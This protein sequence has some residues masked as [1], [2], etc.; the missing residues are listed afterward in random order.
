M[1]DNNVPLY[2]SEGE[3]R[4]LATM[5]IAAR[6][7][8]MIAGEILTPE[9][10]KSLTLGDRRTVVFEGAKANIDRAKIQDIT[11]KANPPSDWGDATGD[12]P[13]DEPPASLREKLGA[14]RTLEAE[15]W[16]ALR[17]LDRF[18]FELVA[19]EGPPERLVK[20]YEGLF[21]REEAPRPSPAA[22]GHFRMV[23]THRATASARV[24]M[25]VETLALFLGGDTPPEQM[26]AM[27]RV[28]G[29]QAGKH[30]SS[31]LP[32]C[33][34]SPI[35]RVEV[36][37][38]ADYSLGCVNIKATVEAVEKSGVDT[39]A[40]VAASVAALTIGDFAKHVDRAV[41]IT[42]VQLV[43]DYDLET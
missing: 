8:L 4:D 41:S 29:I 23:T 40:M 1:A 24:Q 16:A 38:Q 31:L 14:E 28:A 7:A 39:E 30:A 37:C 9:G 42:E 35:T 34:P 6:R 11:H 27:A 19:N 18:A 10:W 12:P 20:F 3:K 2:D 21:R 13:A 25:R 17:P 36:V 15:Q 26:F 33:Y 32:L 22:S 5:P 43:E